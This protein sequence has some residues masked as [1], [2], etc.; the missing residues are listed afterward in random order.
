LT[1]RKDR[2][3]LS[4]STRSNLIL[5]VHAIDVGGGL[6]TV[7]SVGVAE[8]NVVAA[9]LAADGADG[10]DGVG[11]SGHRHRRQGNCLGRLR[12]SISKVHDVVGWNPS[13]LDAVN[14]VE[15]PQRQV[16]VSHN[17][18]AITVGLIDVVV[19]SRVAVGVSF[20]GVLPR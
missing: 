13:A 3:E 2:D 1:G 4:H 20:P 6:E 9:E 19:V 10:D 12:T 16:R 15:R 8:G 5:N 18:G 17:A 11:R 14:D 7:I